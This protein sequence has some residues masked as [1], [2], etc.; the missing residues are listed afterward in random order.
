MKH[1]NSSDDMNAMLAAE[2]AALFVWVNWSIY[3]RHGSEI[4]RMVRSKFT[5][6]RLGASVSWFVADLSFPGATPVAS[7]LHG[8]LEEQGKEANVRL[9]PNID[10]GN[11]STV[12]I[13]NGR[14]VGFEPVALRSGVEGLASSVEAAFDTA[15]S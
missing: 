13:R 8:W 15:S 7:A 4:F 12:L 14:V 2:N 10:M 6:H 9:F 3:A 11:G 1:V 5:E